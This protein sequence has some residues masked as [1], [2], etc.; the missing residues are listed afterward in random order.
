M[1]GCHESQRRGRAQAAPAKA[2]QPGGSPAGGLRE[3][4]Q[5]MNHWGSEHLERGDCRSSCR[6]CRRGRE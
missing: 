4:A 2:R 1:P 6:G 3:D 5:G